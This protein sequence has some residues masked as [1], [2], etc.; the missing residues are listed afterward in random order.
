M[1]G[2]VYSFVCGF[3]GLAR[4]KLHQT[5]LF[6]KAAQ[7]AAGAQD[8]AAGKLVSR[9]DAQSRPPPSAS[10]QTSGGA[11]SAVPAAGVLDNLLGQELVAARVA[12]EAALR[13]GELVEKER[14]R[15]Q[16]SLADLQVREG[17][18]GRRRGE[19]VSEPEMDASRVAIKARLCLD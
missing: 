18:G 16:Y 11:R 15:V 17:G 19:A 6:V 9:P 8:P 7:E 10:Q 5:E 12:E 13:R 3:M 4:A 1:T 14:D 2:G